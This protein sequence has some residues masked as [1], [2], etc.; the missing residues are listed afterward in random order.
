MPR[1]SAVQSYSHGKMVEKLREVACH[2]RMDH[3]QQR[4]STL[5][6]LCDWMDGL[7]RRV[8]A[9][10]IHEV[11]DHTMHAFVMEFDK[12]VEVY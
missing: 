5:Y 6:E 3:T 11:R 10:L 12:R 9:G 1:L 7:S 8:G 4:E 2:S